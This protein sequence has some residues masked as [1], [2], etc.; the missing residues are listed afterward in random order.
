[1]GH[2]A[3]RI[4]KKI[5]EGKWP[6]R[7]TCSFLDAVSTIVGRPASVHWL[8]LARL[9]TWHQGHAQTGLCALLP[10][11]F[12][13]VEPISD[14]VNSYLGANISTFKSTLIRS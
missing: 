10:S 2:R 13:I 12:G 4:G 11:H 7:M 6:S 8:G 3:K 1:M 9:A 14:L 5:C